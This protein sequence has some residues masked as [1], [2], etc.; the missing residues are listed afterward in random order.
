MK[1]FPIINW[2]RFFAALFFI[3]VLFGGFSSGQTAKNQNRRVKGRVLTSEEMPKIRLKFDKK[4]KFVGSQEFVLYDRA[5]AEQYFFVE[6]ENQKI[7][8]MYM[9]QFEGFLPSIKAT[10][11]YNEPQSVEIGGLRYFSN[12]EIVPNVSLALQSVPDSD[13]A[14]AAKFL[15]DKG[16]KL[17]NSLIYQRFVRVVDENKRNE[18]ILLYIEDSENAE[19]S[20]PAQKE[21]MMQGLRERALANF[22]TQK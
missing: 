6:A 15:Q 11:D 3:V 14:R 16:F 7:K 5:K 13:I 1:N 21:K 8:R 22:K 12:T 20:N 19:I 10:Y 17:M 4:F 9:L 2:C 18:F